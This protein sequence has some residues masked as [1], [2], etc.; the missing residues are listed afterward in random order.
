[1]DNPFRARRD[2]AE[3]CP[4]FPRTLSSARFVDLLDGTDHG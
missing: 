1:M 4:F 2:S 3:A